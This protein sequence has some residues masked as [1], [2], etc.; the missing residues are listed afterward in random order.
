MGIDAGAG[1]RGNHDSGSHPATA[2]RADLADCSLSMLLSH[3][4]EM[5]RIKVSYKPC[6]ATGAGLRDDQ[7]AVPWRL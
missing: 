1:D 3:R 4:R 7:A 5:R 6:A 2:G